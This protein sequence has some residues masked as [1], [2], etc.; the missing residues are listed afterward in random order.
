MNIKQPV[1]RASYGQ[2][3]IIGKYTTKKGNNFEKFDEL[4]H[5]D[6]MDGS[7]R[8]KIKPD[9]GK[10]NKMKKYDEK[11]IASKTG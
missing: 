7:W 2:S 6:R 10:G 9:K 1:A 8:K 11:I 5:F 3:F 4:Y